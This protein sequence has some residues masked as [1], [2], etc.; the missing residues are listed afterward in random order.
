MSKK[1]IDTTVFAV[2]LLGFIVI[3]L[4]CATCALMYALDIFG[5]LR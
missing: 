1:F 4:I 2:F 3:G 5:L